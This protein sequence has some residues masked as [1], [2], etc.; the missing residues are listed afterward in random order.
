[1]G[2]LEEDEWTD[3]LVAGKLVSPRL[4]DRLT[5]L[6]ILHRSYLTPAHIARCNPQWDPLCP[7]CKDHN[8][9]FY[10]LIWSCPVIRSYWEQ[11]V[12]FLHDDMGSPLTL[13]PKQ[14]LLGILS[15]HEQNRP[16]HIFMQESLFVVR[17]LIARKWLWADT[18][19]LQ[20]W[21]ATVNQSLPYKNMIYKH[22]NCPAKY[23]KIWD[24]W[25]KST[26]TSTV[27]DSG[28]D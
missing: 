7:R 1:M 2:E 11:L 6:Y 25:L 16:L 21:M 3:A 10:H 22:R 5:H 4:A 8:S 17:L 9:S 14:C 13:C 26:S 12:K 27:L 15:E 28:A 18:P 23:H 24:H 20:E 19:T